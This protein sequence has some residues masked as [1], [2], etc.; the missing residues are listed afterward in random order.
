MTTKE[1]NILSLVSKLD[2]QAFPSVITTDMIAHVP[3][4]TKRDY[5]AGLAM[6]GMLTQLN[7]SDANVTGITQTAVIMADALCRALD[8][9]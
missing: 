6:Q 8:Q 2:H 4:L 3:G 9:S 5:F 7:W 1:E